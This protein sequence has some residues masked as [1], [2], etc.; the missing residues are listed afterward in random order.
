MS[1]TPRTHA[2]AHHGAQAVPAPAGQ[3]GAE[4]GSDSP[5][6]QGRR[7]GPQRG[8]LINRVGATA[9][10]TAAAV[11]GV[12]LAPGLGTQAD[13]ATLSAKALRI[14]AAKRGA[15][16]VFGAA[17]PSRFDCSGLVMWSYRKAGKNLPRTAQAQYNKTRHIGQNS[18]RPG[19]LV[20]F[21]RGS[22]VYHVG[23]YAGSGRIWHA[24][25]RG[26][27]VRLERIWTKSVWY[28]RIG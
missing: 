9:V 17:G 8:R 11:A 15:P 3:D 27:R 1:A 14:A 23:I 25:H 19:D 21:H 10:L 7:V 4:E 26:A 16:Y 13:A 28:G 6:H 5:S 2:P 12:G 22:S 24:P 18:R 20:F